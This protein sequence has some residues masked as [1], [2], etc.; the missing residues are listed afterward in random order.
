MQTT[1]LPSFIKAPKNTGGQSQ[2]VL[3][4]R[5]TVGEARHEILSLRGHEEKVRSC[6]HLKATADLCTQGVRTTV[7]GLRRGEAA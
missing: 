5:I 4:I 6:G 1:P 2:L 3:L 7:S